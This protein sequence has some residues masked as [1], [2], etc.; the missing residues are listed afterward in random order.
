M[1]KCNGL[2]EMLWNE[3]VHGCM[4]LACTLKK[5]LWKATVVSTLSCPVDM[6]AAQCKSSREKFPID[7]SLC[8]RTYRVLSISYRHSQCLWTIQ[9]FGLT[10]HSFFIIYWHT[11]TQLEVAV[12]PW[13][14]HQHVFALINYRMNTRL[15]EQCQS[16]CSIN[17][18][19]KSYQMQTLPH[20]LHRKFL[21]YIQSLK[22]SIIIYY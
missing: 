22:C 21:Y 14:Q 19:N 7:C 5:A 12:M 13:L 11:S 3:M 20:F 16:N 9:T 4:G 6:W 8:W 10:T 18:N 17:I 1:E 15:L 2:P